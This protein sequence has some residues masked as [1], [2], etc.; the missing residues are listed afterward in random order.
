M[1][2]ISFQDY[3]DRD[4]VVVSR[5]RIDDLTSYISDK[6]TDNHEKEVIVIFYNWLKAIFHN[7]NNPFSTKDECELSIIKR[8][9]G[10]ND[11]LSWFT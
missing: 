7:N 10:N 4:V 2:L 11:I 8:S 6:N 1:I 3:T 5:G 9:L